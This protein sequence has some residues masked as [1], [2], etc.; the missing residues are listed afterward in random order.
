MSSGATVGQGRP[1]TEGDERSAAA[2]HGGDERARSVRD[3]ERRNET[4]NEVVGAFR[5]HTSPLVEVA[6]IEPA[7]YG[8]DPGLLRA[9][10]AN[11]FLS[12]GEQAGMLPD[13]LSHC[14]MFRATP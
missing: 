11:D 10:P 6:G 12:P 1:P 3:A 8:T 13:G 9:Q 4:R 14:L 2:T 7:S 5:R